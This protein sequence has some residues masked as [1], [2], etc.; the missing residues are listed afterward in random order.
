MIYAATQIGQ[1]E[2]YAHVV[3]VQQSNLTHR[4]RRASRAGHPGT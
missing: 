2:P 3:H 1:E 4:V